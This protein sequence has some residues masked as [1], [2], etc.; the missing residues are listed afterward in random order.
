MLHRDF[1][2][3]PD[4][5]HSETGNLRLHASEQSL[6]GAQSGYRVD[7]NYE[8]QD[9]PGFAWDPG[10]ELSQLLHEHRSMEDHDS[11]GRHEEPSPQDIPFPSPR[12]E[13]SPVTG[14]P[15]HRRA[16]TSASKHPL[17]RKLSHSTVI[18]TAIILALV[19]TLGCFISYRF[20]SGFTNAHRSDLSLFSW[21]PLMIY[22]PWLAAS[23]SIL[24]ATMHQRRAMQ[25]WSVALVF[26]AMT[27]GLCVLQASDSAISVVI[28][29][30][31]SVA[32]LTC[33]QQF[34]HQIS[35]TR[36]PRRIE[37]RHRQ[38]G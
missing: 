9:T 14:M 24:H 12:T 10:V 36:P 7:D 26:S 32:A 13:R 22:F 29:V 20:L 2:N 4:S 17:I 28:A 6:L 33:L 23:L 15:R 5:H 27:S 19:S 11:H 30:L 1:W 37:P 16:S 35:L 8:V 21:W 34:I 38:H 18:M 31:P 3:S 25:S